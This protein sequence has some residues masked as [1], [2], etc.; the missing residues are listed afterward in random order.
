MLPKYRCN[1]FLL[2]NWRIVKFQEKDIEMWTISEANNLVY[3]SSGILVACSDFRLSTFQLSNVSSPVGHGKK[4]RQANEE[5]ALIIGRHEAHLQTTLKERWEGE[6]RG[7]RFSCWSKYESRLK[8]D[9]P[10]RVSS[11]YHQTNKCPDVDFRRLMNFESVDSVDIG[12]SV[13]GD[14]IINASSKFSDRDLRQ[15][16]VM[17]WVTSCE[18]QVTVQSIINVSKWL[19]KT[20]ESPYK[21]SCVASF[22]KL[23]WVRL[24]FIRVFL[25]S[26]LLMLPQFGCRSVSEM[27]AWRCTCEHYSLVL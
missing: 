14:K 10:F 26:T 2:P 1:F 20:I 25:G 27:K 11:R 24:V 3:V 18:G 4:S 6:R 19:R 16:W 13:N 22:H 17:H 21:P 9:Q 7:S 5:T 8:N 15:L 23:C 12:H